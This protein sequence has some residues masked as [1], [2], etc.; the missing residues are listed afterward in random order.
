MGDIETG[1]Y[2]QKEYISVLLESRKREL[3]R[4]ALQLEIKHS[5]ADLKK[6][7]TTDHATGLANRYCLES[8]ANEWLR[9]AAD[10][11]E[12]IVCIVIDID[13]F[14]CINDQCGHLF[15]DEVIRQVTEACASV[16]RKEDLMGRYGGDE[17][18]VIIRGVPLDVGVRKAEQMLEAIRNLNVSCG[19]TPVPISASLG[20]ADNGAGTVL[21]FKDL[22]Q[23]ADVELYKAK[24]GGR[25]Q[26]S[27]EDL[28]EEQKVQVERGSGASPEAD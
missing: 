6:K 16:L 7:A 4:T 17:F 27:V 28:F 19:E 2:A 12:N 10:R 5:L 9:E 1:F 22:F 24:Q 14:K 18:V 25:N 11:C 23:L 20:V 3:E 13:H 21:Q 26:V 8:T 15:G